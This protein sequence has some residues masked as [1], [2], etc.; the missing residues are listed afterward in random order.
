MTAGGD[1]VFL[2]R[3]GTINVKAPDGEYV[4]TWEEF[5]FLPGAVDAV[6]R[7]AAAGRCVVVVTNQRGVALGQMTEADLADIHRRM[8]DHLGDGAVAAVYHCPHH[9]DA[10]D[11]RKPRPGMLERAARDLGGIDFVRAAVVGDSPSDMQA[12]RA[13]GCKLVV[14]GHPRGEVVDHAAPSLAAAV[15]WLLGTRS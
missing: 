14:I 12:G 13:L 4:T 2:D 7:L 5:H 1:V 11:C 6:R 3:D 9:E 8:L 15:D 10:C